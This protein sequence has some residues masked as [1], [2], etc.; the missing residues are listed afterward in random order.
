LSSVKKSRAILDI[1]YFREQSRG[2]AME[3]LKRISTK[4]HR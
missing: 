1:R 3:L 2:L 4:R